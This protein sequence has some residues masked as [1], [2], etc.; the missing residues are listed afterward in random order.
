MDNATGPY[1]LSVQIEKYDNDRT[2]EDGPP[3]DVLTVSQWFE[4]N[5]EPV[6]DPARIAELNAL[7][8]PGGNYVA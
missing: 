3:D 5:G 1:M 7:T 2:P 4:A 6:T 8:L